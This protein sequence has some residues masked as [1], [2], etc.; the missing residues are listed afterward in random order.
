MEGAMGFVPKHVALVELM[1]K[2]WELKQSEPEQLAF[3][4]V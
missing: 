3:G 2:E 1:C 4:I